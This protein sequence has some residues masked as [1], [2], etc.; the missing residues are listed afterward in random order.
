[1]F[2]DGLHDYMKRPTLYEFTGALQRAED[3][4]VKCDN[5]QCKAYFF[6]QDAAKQTCPWCDVVKQDLC[7]LKLVE[8]SNISDELF[9]GG[10]KKVSR[11]LST[12]TL[13]SEAKA[14]SRR[15]VD[16]YVS[17]DSDKVIAILKRVDR[18]HIVLKNFSD[19]DFLIINSETRQ[20]SVMKPDDTKNL[21]IH[22]DHVLIDIKKNVDEIN[23]VF[24]ANNVLKNFVFTIS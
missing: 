3:Q 21:N 4:L 18:D 17:Q 11:E 15:H 1:M 5:S 16:F 19:N 6:I 9:D 22:K 12:L 10:K 2:V 24:E 8:T 23:E 20:R 14:I 13:D 7:T